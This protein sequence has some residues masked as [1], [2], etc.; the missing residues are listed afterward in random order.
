M[1]M[2][3]NDLSFIRHNLEIVRGNIT[4]ACMRVGRSS[5]EVTLVVVSKFQSVEKI[6]EARLN[7]QLDFGENYP[8]LAL[9]KIQAFKEKNL[10]WHMI[11]HLQSRKAKVVAAHFDYFH[12]LDSLRIAEKLNRELEAIGRTLPVLLEINLSKEASKSGWHVDPAD[13]AEMEMFYKVI[14]TIMM[15]FSHLQIRGL[16]TMPP[17]SADTEAS[18]PFFVKSRLCLSVIK[19]AF[20]GLMLDQLSMGTTQDYEAAI[21]EG[22]THVRIGTAVMGERSKQG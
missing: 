18:R 1:N 12:S 20:P 8:E 21:E 11:G 3:G 9:P 17:F 7:G 19:N 5:N 16:M 14:D 15:K 6:E 2:T 22:S 4:R 10:T 13:S